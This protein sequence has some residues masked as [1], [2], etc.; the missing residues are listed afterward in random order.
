MTTN[1][2]ANKKAIVALWHASNKG[3]TET[4]RELANLLIHTFP[5]HRAVHPVPVSVPVA[6]DFRLV[7]DVAGIIV[8]IES[9]GDPNTGLE[10]RLDDLVTNFSA[11]I[12]F[13]TT[14]TKGETVKAVDRTAA[15]GYRGIWTSTYQI[16]RDAGQTDSSLQSDRDLANKLKARHLLELMWSLNLLPPCAPPGV[17]SSFPT[18]PSP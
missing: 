15:K 10:K 2:P 16:E 18:A 11:G 3:K 8:A 13:C 1:T 9:K 14:R 6:G 7:I 17:R 12:I 5:N 4:L